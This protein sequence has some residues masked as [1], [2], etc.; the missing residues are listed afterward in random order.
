MPSCPE[1]GSSNWREQLNKQLEIANVHLAGLATE[2][3]Q[4]DDLKSR[5]F[6]QGAADIGDWQWDVKTGKVTW[7]QEVELMHGLTPGS[8]A[9]W[10]RGLDQDH[11][12]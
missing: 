12:S 11:S 9:R 8:F 2:L 10:L 3:R 7:S 1:T 6:A 4:L 5:F